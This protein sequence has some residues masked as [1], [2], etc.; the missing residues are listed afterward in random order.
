MRTYEQCMLLLAELDGAEAELR[1]V[2][3][4]NTRAWERIQAGANDPVDW[5]AL[6][7][8]IHTLYGIVENYFVRISKFF[9]NG[10]PKDRWHRVLLERMALDISGVRPP[11]FTEPTHLK[12]AYE[13]LAFRHRIRNLYGED[14]DPLKTSAV[15]AVAQRFFAVFS[16]LHQNYRVRILAIAEALR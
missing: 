9:E 4:Q 1:R 12:D 10:I 13:L 7:Y 14:L 8:T 3:P 5:G 2:L 16:T 15:Q 11:F 6:G